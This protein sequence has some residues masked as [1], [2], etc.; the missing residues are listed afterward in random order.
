M[1]AVTAVGG[2]EA[3]DPTN[4]LTGRKLER[5]LVVTG[6]EKSIAARYVETVAH[7]SWEGAN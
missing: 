6:F 5:A 1:S 3:P 2:T 4:A 7:I